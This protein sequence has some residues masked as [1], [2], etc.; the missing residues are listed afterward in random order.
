M[1]N[2]APVLEMT[3][4]SSTLDQVKVHGAASIET[5]A[6]IAKLTYILD[7]VADTADKIGG[8][9]KC[10]AGMITVF[11]LVVLCAWTVA[12]WEETNRVENITSVSFAGSECWLCYVW[13]SLVKIMNKFDQME[14]TH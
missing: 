5:G 6:T 1:D 13:R 10:V 4:S 2:V 3:A 14:H 8:V 11:T 9:A 7:S 12:L